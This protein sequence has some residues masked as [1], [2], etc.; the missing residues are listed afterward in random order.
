M[1][2]VL[3]AF[4]L[5]LAAF[6]TCAG[7]DPQ[8]M[9]KKPILPC[10]DAQESILAAAAKFGWPPMTAV[11]DREQEMIIFQ[12]KSSEGQLIQVVFSKRLR[13]HPSYK[14]VDVCAR[15]DEYFFI[16]TATVDP[17]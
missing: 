10:R 2:Y 3:Y 9:T 7:V 12:W 6:V 14:L 13:S 17:V 11:V 16:Y 1:R 5:A 4:I 15:N 8:T